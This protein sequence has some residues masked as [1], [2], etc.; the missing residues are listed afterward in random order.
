[1]IGFDLQKLAK[2]V[3]SLRELEEPRAAAGVADGESPDD[4][5]GRWEIAAKWCS[6]V[7]HIKRMY[8]AV[9]MSIMFVTTVFLNELSPV[10]AIRQW[11]PREG[12]PLIPHLIRSHQ[13]GI[14]EGAAQFSGVVGQAAAGVDE[15]GKNG[16][17]KHKSRTIEK[18][19]FQGRE[20]KAKGTSTGKD[21]PKFTFRTS[22]QQLKINDAASTVLEDNNDAA[23]TAMNDNDDAFPTVAEDDDE[24]MHELKRTTP[25]PAGEL[26][27]VSDDD[28][29]FYEEVRYGDARGVLERFEE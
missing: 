28:V 8:G 18:I 19:I 22:F 9:E 15:P 2:A 26:A 10:D 20:D 21:F 14:E 13:L 16:T 17:A 24:H 1:M 6:T 4:R 23:T 25:S 11:Y 12:L 3:D 5:I 27:E 7:P 29:V